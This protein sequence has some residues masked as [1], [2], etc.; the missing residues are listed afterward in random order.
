MSE[1]LVG[2]SHMRIFMMHEAT[3]CLFQPI[4]KESVC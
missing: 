1:V 3:T 4:N 2:K